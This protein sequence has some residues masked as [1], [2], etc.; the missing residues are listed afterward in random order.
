MV[1]SPATDYSPRLG[2]CPSSASIACLLPEPQLVFVNA[3]EA[4]VHVRVHHPD[5]AFVQQPDYLPQCVFAT[6]SRSEAKA[7]RIGVAATCAR[8]SSLGLSFTAP[9]SC[10]PSLRFYGRCTRSVDAHAPAAGW[11]SRTCLCRA[12]VCVRHAQAGGLDCYHYCGIS[13]TANC[14]CGLLF[15][16]EFTTLSGII[17][18]RI[19]R[20]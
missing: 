17:G 12:P 9:P 7:A 3:V 15:A 6:A 4:C 20:L 11:P 13:E 1:N 5:A 19:V 8:W 2:V 14:I 18:N 16:A 10:V